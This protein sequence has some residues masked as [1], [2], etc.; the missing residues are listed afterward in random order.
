MICVQVLCAIVLSFIQVDRGRHLSRWANSSL[1]VLLI[2]FSVWAGMETTNRFNEATNGPNTD[3]I[4][5]AGNTR[6]RLTDLK[7]QIDSPRHI[8][9][10]QREAG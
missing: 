6:G 2:A 8:R 1:S 3:K 9:S 5:K 10:Y 4:A 7:G